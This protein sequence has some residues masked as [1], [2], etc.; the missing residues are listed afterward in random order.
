M[1]DLAFEK[2]KKNNNNNH[3]QDK[4]YILLTNTRA[5]LR[6]YQ[7]KVLHDSEVRTEK[8]NLLA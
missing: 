8:F 3:K 7:P 4:R 6:E 5:I 2:I 1:L